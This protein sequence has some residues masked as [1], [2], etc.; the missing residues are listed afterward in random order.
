[1]NDQQDWIAAAQEIMGLIAD[2]VP[3]IQFID[4]W[5]EQ[6]DFPE[7]EY[8]FPLPAVF[9]E[10]NA[11]KIDDLGENVQ[12]LTTEVKVYLLFI[13]T[14]DTHQSGKGNG[15]LSAFGALLRDL[16]KLLQGTAGDNFSQL[17]R[18]AMARE[19]AA[20]FEWC[21]SQTFS[22]LIRDYAACK[23]FEEE[24]PGDLSVEKGGIPA[25]TQDDTYDFT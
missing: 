18:V 3:A 20:P 24:D 11:Q 8:P 5:A 1:M 23:T 17:S 15:D 4:L 7:D 19:K 6:T 16:Y 22:G 2:N 25:T 12:D 14:G 9:L 10:F 21:Y 13:P